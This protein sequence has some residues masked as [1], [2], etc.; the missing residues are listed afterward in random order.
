MRVAFRG[1]IVVAA[2]G[3]GLAGGAARADEVLWYNGDFDNNNALSNELNTFL[4][5]ARVYDDFDVTGGTWTIDRIWSNNLMNF[6]GV[7]QADWSIRSGVSAGNGGTIIA[8]GTSA[9]TQTATGRSGFGAAEYTIEVD[10]LSIALA[11]GTYWLQ[12]TPIGSGAGRAFNS[13]TSG[14]N[15]I[16][17]PAGNNENSFFTSSFFS[18]NFEPASDSVGQG[19]GNFSMGVA[20][21][22]SVP[23]P[24]TLALLGLGLAG[25]AASRR[26]KQ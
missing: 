21:T 23:E 19:S 12:V 8:S 20:G 18:A 14:T 24:T 1:M 4:N 2:I 25:L 17:S 9:A 11:P 13:T 6:T 5:D 7:T 26:R 3:M 10:G 22:A 16:G 15:A